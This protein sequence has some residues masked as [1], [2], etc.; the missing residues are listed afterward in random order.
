M[1]DLG[2]A[3]IRW[4]GSDHQVEVVV[5]EGHVPEV[6]YH[7]RVDCHVLGD[8]AVG[9]VP[10]LLADVHESGV[11]FGLVPPE[12]AGSAAGVQDA[13]FLLIVHDFSLLSLLCSFTL[14]LMC[15]CV[16]E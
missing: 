8:A 16:T 7:V 4:G 5:R 9:D 14:V 10:V 11:G 6:G 3:Q 13:D 1:K 12:H 2:P 15:D